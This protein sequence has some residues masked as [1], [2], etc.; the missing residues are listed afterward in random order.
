MT[1][2]VMGRFAAR[3]KSRFDPWQNMARR[4]P[5][6]AQVGVLRTSSP[7][8][9]VDAGDLMQPAAS[10]APPRLNSGCRCKAHHQLDG[11]VDLAFAADG[12]CCTIELP[13]LS[14]ASS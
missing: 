5:R 2:R 11:R 14:Q 6:P 10:L 8:A 12:V 4:G 9:N 3:H 13:R 1:I 7:S